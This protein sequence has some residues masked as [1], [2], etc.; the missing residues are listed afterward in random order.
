L[1]VWNFTDLCN[2]HCKHCYQNVSLDRL[3]KEL[4]RNEALRAVDDMADAGAAYVALSG[5]EPLIRPN[6][7]DVIDRITDHEMGLAVATNATLLNED[8]VKRL[9]NMMTHT[10]R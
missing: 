2:L 8:T 6:F 4:S 3:E 9:K 5:G 7:F 1:V 10:F